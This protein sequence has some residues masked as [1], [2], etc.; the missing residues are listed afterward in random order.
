MEMDDQLRDN[1]SVF[2][3]QTDQTQDGDKDM[4]PAPSD[5]FS[6]AAKLTMAWQEEEK[7]RKEEEAARMAAAAAA[8]SAAAPATAPAAPAA[9]AAVAGPS[10]PK[11]V[12]KKALKRQEG[13]DQRNAIAVQI[14]PDERDYLD[15]CELSGRDPKMAPQV[16]H[17]W[18]Q[19]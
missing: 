6:T 15:Y 19:E 16:T 8:A 3:L 7:K 5:I 18:S 14:W 17:T 12:D 13:R 2:P 9:P 4:A 11:K 1:N 10:K